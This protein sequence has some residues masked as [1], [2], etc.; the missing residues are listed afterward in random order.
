MLQTNDLVTLVNEQDEVIGQ[1]D[2]LEAHRDG[3][4]LHRAISIFL[5]RTNEAGVLELLIQQRSDQKIVGARQW[6]NTACGNVWPGES[7]KQCAQRRLWV[8]LGVG[9]D[10]LVLTD[11]HHFQYQ[12][13]CNEQFGENELDHVFVGQFDGSCQPNSQEVSEIAW[14]AWSEVVNQD[15]RR[16]SQY[17]WA[18]WFEIMTS[19]EQLVQTVSQHAK[20]N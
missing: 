2:K 6:A 16:Q 19:S 20:R 12:V 15:W 3:G 14:V 10:Q 1:M 18:P 5:F 9:D 11:V 17:D 4:K 13:R 7:Y 8:E